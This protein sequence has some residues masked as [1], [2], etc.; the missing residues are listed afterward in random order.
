MHVHRHKFETK[1]VASPL[2]GEEVEKCRLNQT[3]NCDLIFDSESDCGVKWYFNLTPSLTAESQELL[4][5]MVYTYCHVVE[6][7][8]RRA[9]E[10]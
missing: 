6:K 10:G 8:A 7:D 4:D 3:Y 2:L 5:Y 9:F 1:W